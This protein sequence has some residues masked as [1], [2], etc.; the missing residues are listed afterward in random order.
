MAVRFSMGLRNNMLDSIGL[1]ESF[2]NGVLK[3]YS[4]VQP[5]SSN[6]PAPG[7]LLLEVSVDGLPFNPG[8]STN[9]LNFD[10][11][12]SAIVSKAVGENWQGSGIASGTAGWARLCGNMAD[13]GSL[14]ETLPRIDMS[15]AKTG[16]DL[17]LSNTAIVVA[18]PTTVD[19]FS[20]TM[21]ET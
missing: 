6:D 10:I 2:A 14:S 1:R 4:G 11:P 9:G 7:V 12:V 15:V 5:S 16:A 18:A 13:P 19:I 3:I 17:N 8:V 21:A 20:V